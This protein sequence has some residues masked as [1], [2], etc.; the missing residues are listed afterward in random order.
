MALAPAELSAAPANTNSSQWSCSAGPTGGWVC[1]PRSVPGPVY[2]RPPRR[3]ATAAAAAK[4]EPVAP[5]A[6]TAADSLDWVPLERLSPEQLK[7]ARPGCCGAY[8]EPG[9]TS[10]DA[11][12]SPADAPLRATADTTDAQGETATLNGNVQITQGS[13]QM[14]S[15]RATIDRG[16]NQAVFENHIQFRDAGLL[17]LGDRA[18]I[19]TKTQALSVDNATFA[20]HANSSRG[21]AT[22]FHRDD[23]GV[24]YINDATYTTCEP[25]SNS[26]LLRTGSVR[27]GA[28]R[29]FATAR[30]ARVEIKDI[31]LLYTPWIR[32]PLDDDRAT[33]LLFPQLAMSNRNGF[34]YAQP[35]YL[36]LAPNYDATITPRFLQSRG[37]MLEAEF[38]HLSLFDNTTIAGAFLPND[39]SNDAGSSLHMDPSTGKNSLN[40]KDRWLVNVT[41]SGGAGHAWYTLVDYTKVS[42]IDYFRDLGNSTL[43]VNSQ[44]HLLQE[45]AA[46]YQFA[47]WAL[48]VANIEYQTIASNLA[49]QYKEL[50]RVNLDGAYRFDNNLEL[51]LGNEY[52]VFDNSDNRMV[53]GER[54][55][56]NYGAAWD[57]RWAWGYFRPEAKLKHI[58]Y[59]LDR[60]TLPG[61]NDNPSTTVPVADL[62][63]GLYF[64][65]S[66]NLFKGFTQ[67]LEPRIY[68]LNSK[69]K[70]QTDNPDFD[71]TDLTFSYQQLFRD[72]RFS[73]GDRIGDANQ[74][75][76]GLTTRLVDDRGI[77]RLRGSIGRIQYLEDRYV[78]LNPTFTKSF[79]DNLGN[80]Q[81][82]TDVTQR[83]V[84]RQ[85][86]SNDSPYA[87]EFFAR[88][89]N[90][91]RFQSD[92]A[93]DDQASQID[94]GNASL[95][96]RDNQTLINLAY[97]FTRKQPQLV[98]NTIVQTDINQSDVS[99]YY[100]VSPQWTLI[101]RWSH[102]FTYSRELEVM[103]GLEYGSC[104]WKLALL[105]RR[106][107]NRDN[108]VLLPDDLSY[109]QGIFLQ[110]QLI[111]L[112]GTGQQVDNI[113]KDSIYGYEPGKR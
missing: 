16:T 47:N 105:A 26:W 93:Y 68:Y 30:N 112:A 85:L 23:E 22:H 92:I 59:T 52:I 99:T 80:L 55:R 37:E 97:R 11:A 74:V 40:G 34:D 86:L 24:I 103:G 81:T 104:C 110:I 101:G 76:L 106:W 57:E 5:D 79:L 51:N 96:Y 18:Q 71:T 20:F 94:K 50:P 36:N 44:P 4:A 33:G 46:G 38:R 69:F 100:P 12:L 27:V 35:I 61:A 84:A 58:G 108:T 67:T 107:L 13:R 72:D 82:L 102:D 66:S 56:T 15:D 14:R 60:P 31:P 8:I 109:S 87:G 78:S 88:L 90:H 6:V 64:E 63:T 43:D 75:T 32:F 53:T 83:D 95:R 19:D 77:E 48:N 1:A 65:R 62:D 29:H 89:S 9:N 73:G 25:A 111:G 21:T 2:E 91:W 45:I 42:D 54:L 39:S 10:P 28:D 3:T 98:N 17:L 7:N 49:S 113:L 70:D 41:N